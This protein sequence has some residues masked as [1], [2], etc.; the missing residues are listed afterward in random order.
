MMIPTNI[1]SCLTLN[2]ALEHARTLKTD[3]IKLCLEL[4]RHEGARIILFRQLRPASKFWGTCM[5]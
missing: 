3:V 5:V 2:L 4:L 1:F